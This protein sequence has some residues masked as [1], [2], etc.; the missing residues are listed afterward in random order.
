[1]LIHNVNDDIS[2]VMNADRSLTVVLDK[3][4]ELGMPFHGRISRPLPDGVFRE[5]ANHAI[6]IVGIHRIAVDFYKPRTLMFD[7][8][9]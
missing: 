4:S 3:F 5:Q 8:Q 7:L 2:N 6:Y 9:P 1:M